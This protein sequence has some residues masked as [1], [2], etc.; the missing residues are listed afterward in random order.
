MKSLQFLVS[1]LFFWSLQHRLVDSTTVIKPTAE[2][3]AVTTPSNVACAM[4]ICPTTT[5]VLK[6]DSLEC[7]SE[8]PSN[9]EIVN[10]VCCPGVQK[11]VCKENNDA[12][13]TVAETTTPTIT[14]NPTATPSPE[15]NTSH[16]TSSSNP[17]PT[18]PTGSQ[19]VSTSPATVTASTSSSSTLANKWS[20]IVPIL[21][22]SLVSIGLNIRLFK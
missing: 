13:S 3:S 14:A 18:G 22:P 7:P 2:V 8:C 19:S 11:A 16:L 17:S 1:L 5:A 4:T 9:C 21:F 12:S 10:N 15:T 20:I 6:R